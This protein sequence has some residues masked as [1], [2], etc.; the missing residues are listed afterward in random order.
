MLLGAERAHEGGQRD[1]G[2]PP[3]RDHENGRFHEH[4][5][6][7]FRRHPGTQLNTSLG[8]TRQYLTNLLCFISQGAKPGDHGADDRSIE[9]KLAVGHQE[10]DRI[11][12]EVEQVFEASRRP[13]WVAS[14]KLLVKWFSS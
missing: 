11:V 1:R 7:A 14:F 10:L 13:N 4:V 12:D 8:R 3:E 5:A 9:H 6:T 2:A